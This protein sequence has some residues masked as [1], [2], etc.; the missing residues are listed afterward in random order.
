MALILEQAEDS[1]VLNEE[2]K[3]WLYFRMSRPFP[4]PYRPW[5]KTKKKF[6]FKTFS[7]AEVLASVE[8]LE[9]TD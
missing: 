1:E 5:P 8:P 3:Q 7:F 6:E 2:Q 9:E 4:E